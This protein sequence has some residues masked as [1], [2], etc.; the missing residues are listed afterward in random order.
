VNIDHALDQYYEAEL[1]G[2][3]C[4]NAVDSRPCLDCDTCIEAMEEDDE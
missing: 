3:I 1:D 4:P 2:P